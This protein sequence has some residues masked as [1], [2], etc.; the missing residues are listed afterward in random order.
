MAALRPENNRVFQGFRCT[1]DHLGAAAPLA[2]LLQRP[3]CA[4]EGSDR[5]R[6]GAAPGLA[7]FQSLYRS[8]SPV[9][10]LSQPHLASHP[11]TH[12]TGARLR[13]DEKALVLS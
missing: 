9:R 2:A 8:V 4:P 6:T 10:A 7:G 1:D 13:Y 11:F 3:A 5:A 12:R